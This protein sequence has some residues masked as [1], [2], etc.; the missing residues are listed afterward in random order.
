MLTIVSKK[1]WWT[2]DF[3]VWERVKHIVFKVIIQIHVGRSKIKVKY[4]IHVDRS[5]IKVKYQIHVPYLGLYNAQDF[6][7]IFYLVGGVPIIKRNNVF[8][9][10]DICFNITSIYM[11]LIFY[12][13]YLLYT[14]V[15][16]KGSSIMID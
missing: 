4:Q 12:F 15:S 1:T 5:K 7:H 11:N 9:S 13:S 3:P 16:L 2:F 8:H 6:A 10:F 14:R